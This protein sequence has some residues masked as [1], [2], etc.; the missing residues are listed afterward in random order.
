MA[1]KVYK[2]YIPIKLSSDVER[3]IKENYWKESYDQLVCQGFHC[4]DKLEI[5][6]KHTHVDIISMDLLFTFSNI[7]PESESEERE[8][9]DEDGNYIKLP[10]EKIQEVG[11]Q[12]NKYGNYEMWHN[13]IIEQRC[14]LFNNSKGLFRKGKKRYIDNTKQILIKSDSEF[15]NIRHSLPFTEEDY[16]HPFIE[17]IAENYVAYER[18]TIGFAINIHFPQRF[19][20]VAGNQIV[21]SYLRLINYH[22][23]TE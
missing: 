1:E 13:S 4:K 18:T 3:I 19:M 21:G 10:N 7:N 15:M 5:I 12:Y 2:D 16:D 6:P 11:L 9:V 22:V 20:P 23:V 17:I 14:D 8:I